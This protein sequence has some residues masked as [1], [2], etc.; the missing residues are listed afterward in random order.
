MR[1]LADVARSSLTTLATF[2]VA[3]FGLAGALDLVLD[4]S[5]EMAAVRE[6]MIVVWL[7]G[8]IAAVATRA[9]PERMRVPWLLA[10][11]VALAAVTVLARESTG[12]VAPWIQVTLAAGML[13]V[14]A[15][16]C[17]PYQAVPWTSLAIVVLVLAPQRWDE[18]ARED[19]P[20]RLGVP[21]VE[22]AL[23]V[24]LGLLGALIRAVLLQSAQRADS[25]LA[26]AEAERRAAIAERTREDALRAHTA[27]LH[28]TALNTLNAI[29][30]GAQGSQE[31]TRARC[32][33]DADR[34]SSEASDA[35]PSSLDDA[36]DGA[37]ARARLLG[38]AL[39]VTHTGTT[40]TAIPVT[41]LSALAGA[42]EEALLNVVKHAHTSEVTLLVD[43]SPGSVNLTVTDHGA[44][45]DGDQSAGFGIAT[46]MRA[47]MRAVGGSADVTSTPGAGTQVSLAWSGERPDDVSSTVSDSVQRLLVVF[48][49]A[50]TTFTSAV[51]VAERAAFER[52]AV[53]LVGGLLLGIWGLAVT[54][55]LQRRRW[56]PT[57]VGVLTVALACLAPFWTIAS[58]QYCASSLGGVGWVDPRLA[59]VVLVILTTGHWP[60]ATIAVPAVVAAAL[61]AGSVWDGAYAGCSGWATSAALYAVAVLSASLIAVRTL[62]RQ[63][64]QLVRA[65]RDR[66][67]AEES[68]ARAAAL[69]AEQKEWLYPALAHCVPLLAALGDGRLDPDSDQARGRCRVESAHLRSLVTVAAAPAGI[70]EALRDVVL[71]GHRRGFDVVVRGVVDEMPPAP[72]D[73]ADA[74][75][76]LV[77]DADGSGHELALLVTP[78]DARGSIIISAPTLVSSGSAPTAPTAPMMDIT[79]DDVGGWWAQVSW[80]A[81]MSEASAP[82]PAASR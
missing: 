56:I 30:L 9:F 24:G 3:F 15:A 63:A 73:L 17:L 39:T 75:T 2:W 37:I 45:F 36:V 19:S 48:M 26:E 59:L 52:P 7:T 64:S 28:D 82:E 22:A 51:V 58:D 10:V 12:L 29:A 8:S 33:A 60:R 11:A 79:L 40:G 44:G 31:S 70:R 71:L 67:D 66:D 38:L 68:R 55:L 50:T 18:M 80:P 43:E 42:T 13:S 35:A 16:L 21:L 81:S 25:T 47:R 61:V 74:L 27:L 1:S 53:A 69:R 14:A 20:V 72:P 6:P 77:P 54:W 41:V 49:A 62:N 5:V 34:L 76:P 65:L 46:S 78:H 23:V 4:G 57:S 32:Q